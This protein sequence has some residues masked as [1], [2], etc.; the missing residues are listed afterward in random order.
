MTGKGFIV[1]DFAGAGFTKSFGGSPVCFYLW[2]VGHSFCLS[3]LK[4]D[5]ASNHLSRLTPP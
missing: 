4:I 1:D 2:H 5:G 3:Y